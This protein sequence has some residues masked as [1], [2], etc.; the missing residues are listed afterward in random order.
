MC[1]VV[2]SPANVCWRVMWG[3]NQLDTA[4]TRKEAEQLAAFYNIK[5]KRMG[6]V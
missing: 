3:D 2:R 5:L 6:I 4:D 1:E